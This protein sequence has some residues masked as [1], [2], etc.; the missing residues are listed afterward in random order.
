MKAISLKTWRSNTSVP[1]IFDVHA[2]I[3]AEDAPAK[4]RELHSAFNHS[5]VNLVSNRQSSSTSRWI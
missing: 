5:Q 4:E 3:F 1:F 2:V